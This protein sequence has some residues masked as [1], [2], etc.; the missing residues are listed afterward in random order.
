MYSE[1]GE[2]IAELEG[3]PWGTDTFVGLDYLSFVAYI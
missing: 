3:S 1:L 2:K